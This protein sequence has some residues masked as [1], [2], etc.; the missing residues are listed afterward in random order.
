MKIK[1]IIHER[2]EDAPFIGALVCANDCNFNCKNCFNQHLKEST[3]IEITKEEIIN[4]IKNNIFNNGIILAGLEWTF[5]PKDMEAL[6]LYSLKNN[7]KVMLYTGMEQHKF[8]EHFNHIYNLPIYIKFGRYED[9][10]KSDIH[11]SY[12]VKLA[13]KNQKIT[14]L[15]DRIDEQSNI[16]S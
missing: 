3:S 12:G 4:Q 16:E 2:T 13:S 11:Y 10:N 15:E 8:K 14:S 6:I 9:D 5:Q 1:A 7:L